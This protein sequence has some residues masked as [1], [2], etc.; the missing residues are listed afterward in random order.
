MES[1]PEET[2]LK[3]VVSLFQDQSL[4]DGSFEDNK[5]DCESIAEQTTKVVKPFVLSSDVYLYRTSKSERV[6]KPSNESEENSL[7]ETKDYIP[8]GDIDL[9][10]ISEQTAPMM[11]S[12]RKVL[13]TNK[14]KSNFTKETLNNK[15]KVTSEVSKSKTE[16]K[17]VKSD[18]KPLKVKRLKGDLNRTKRTKPKGKK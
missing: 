14:I 17:I 2:V 1:P 12:D 3:T 7:R 10:D 9:D 16:S 15:N 6:Y 4:M 8:L 11:L 5:T 18:Y 13:K